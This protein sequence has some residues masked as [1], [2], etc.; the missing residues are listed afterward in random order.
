MLKNFNFYL[1]LNKR[2]KKNVSIAVTYHVWLL[3]EFRLKMMKKY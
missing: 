2:E 1:L 3:I